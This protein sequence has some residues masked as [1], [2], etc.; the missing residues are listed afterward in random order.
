[1]VYN[2]T[3]A[4]NVLDVNVDKCCHN[5]GVERFIKIGYDKYK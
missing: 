1:M 5:E 2:M 4:V 3:P